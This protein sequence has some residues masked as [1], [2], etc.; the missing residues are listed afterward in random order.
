MKLAETGIQPRSPVILPRP[1]DGLIS[2]QAIGGCGCWIGLRHVAGAEFCDDVLVDGERIEL[3]LEVVGR[4]AGPDLADHVDRFHALAQ[5]RPALLVAEQL[6]VG[7]QR[8]RPDAEDEPAAAHVVE[9]RGFSRDRRRMVAW[10]VDDAGTELDLLGLRNGRRHEG[11]GIGDRFGRGGEVLADPGF[12]VAELVSQDDLVEILL[13]GFRHVAM[14][15]MQRH[16]ENSEFHFV[17]PGRALLG[18]HR[19]DCRQR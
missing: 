19:L 2:E 17:L 7:R 3:A 15:R 11:E 12:G 16:H 4:S 10:Q 14:R 9:L 5:P 6:E 8:P 1:G 18:R 13:I